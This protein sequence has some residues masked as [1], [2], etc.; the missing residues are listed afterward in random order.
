MKEE[1]RRNEREKK[2]MEEKQKMEFVEGRKKKRRK[3]EITKHD[4]AKGGHCY[5]TAVLVS[6]SQDQSKKARKL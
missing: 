2:R 4:D 6:T 5:P 3:E 1:T